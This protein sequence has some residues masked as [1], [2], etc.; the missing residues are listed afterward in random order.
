MP[1][2]PLD[3]PSSPASAVAQP[4]PSSLCE[5]PPIQLIDEFLKLVY[6]LHGL[7]RGQNLLDSLERNRKEHESPGS[8]Q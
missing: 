7:R 6:R 1:A 4:V 2:L 3:C 5:R 8:N